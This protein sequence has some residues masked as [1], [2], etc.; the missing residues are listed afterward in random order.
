MN[1]QL[2]LRW[3]CAANEPYDMPEDLFALLQAIADTGS[4]RAAAEECAMSY[5]HA[6]GMLQ[7]WQ[8]HFSYPLAELKRGR[9]NGAVLTA[10]GEKLLWEYQRIAA[11]LEPELASLSSELSAELVA[12]MQTEPQHNLRIAASHGL[13]IANL[14]DLAQKTLGLNLDVQFHGSLDSL[15]Q[16]RAGRY[17]IAGFHLPE[18]KLGKAL[19]SRVKRLI[20]PETD[21]LVYA[22][23]RQQGLMMAATNPKNIQKLTDLTRP[24]IKFINRQ[25][26]SGSRITLDEML[27]QAGVDRALIN[28]YANEEFTHSAVAA[29]VA[30]GAADCGFGLQAAA[31]QFNLAFIPFNW[32]SYWFV[33]PKAK[34]DQVL[35]RSFIELLGSDAFK[36]S[37]A[38]LQGYDASR[39]GAV[40]VPDHNL[41]IL[42]F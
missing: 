37:V 18:A 20:N 16:Y 35:F 2:A 11:R 12:L 26:N 28:G 36:L 6:W 4:L 30:S 27:L 25:R 22:V 14:R 9:G 41:S 8:Q 40:V 29:L 21:R 33:M 7:L 10:F 13:V 31:V 39:S 23:R 42:L 24:D 32:E 19:L 17:D 15:Q 5:R 1:I 3:V 34:M 38:K